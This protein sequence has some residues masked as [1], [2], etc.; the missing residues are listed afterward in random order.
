MVLY[1]PPNLT[2]G[3]DQTL[4]EVATVVPS[5]IIGLLLFIFGVVFF[6]GTETQK[7][8]SGYA[9]YPLWSLMA[10]M[11]ILIITLILTINEGIINSLVLGVVVALTIL[12]GLWFFLSR[13]RGE[14]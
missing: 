7:K 4:I 10:S 11:S 14:I 9:D 13:G 1:E 8:R 12:S 3:V 2:G 5:F 6:G